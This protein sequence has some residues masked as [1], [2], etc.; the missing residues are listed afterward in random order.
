VRVPRRGDWPAESVGALAGPAARGLYPAVE[1]LG[2][3]YYVRVRAVFA[4]IPIPAIC[5]YHR[6]V[7][8]RGM[9]HLPNERSGAHI[10]CV[11]NALRGHRSLAIVSTMVGVFDWPWVVGTAADAKASRA[12]KP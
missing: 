4:S 5:P 2:A 12:L 9:R 8:S 7:T 1:A 6:H 3:S 10:C 11:H